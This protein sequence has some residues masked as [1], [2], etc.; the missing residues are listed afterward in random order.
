ML[1]VKNLITG[2]EVYLKS[3]LNVNCY[4]ATVTTILIEYNAEAIN[5]VRGIPHKIPI[6]PVSACIISNAII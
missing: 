5:V 3:T 2:T 6:E 4:S 1:L